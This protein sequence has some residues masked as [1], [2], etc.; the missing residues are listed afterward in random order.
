MTKS[1]NSFRSEMSAFKQAIGVILF[2]VFS[3]VVINT[4]HFQLL[5]VHVVLYDALLDAII[6][7]FITVAAVFVW[8]R[9]ALSVLENILS[10]GVAGLLC[11]FYAVVG[12]AVIDRSLSMYI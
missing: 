6:A 9:S 7:M 3:F 10:V 11:A 4:I 1:P 5:P 8:R 2:C 12:P